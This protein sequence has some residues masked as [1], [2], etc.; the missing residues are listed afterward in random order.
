MSQLKTT[1]HGIKYT[2]VSFNFKTKQVEYGDEMTA[3]IMV[4]EL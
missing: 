4:N 2:R 1:K 3:E